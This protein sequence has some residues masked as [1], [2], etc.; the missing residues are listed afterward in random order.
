MKQY[1][2][3]EVWE[4]IT[5]GRGLDFRY[6]K[7]TGFLGAMC[8]LFFSNDYGKRIEYTSDLATEVLIKKKKIRKEEIV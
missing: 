6:K 8:F 7:T 5:D 3:Y 4:D 2:L 1:R